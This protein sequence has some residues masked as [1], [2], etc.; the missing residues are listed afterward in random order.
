MA[1]DE[2]FRLRLPTALRKAMDVAAADE[3]ESRSA[4]VRNTLVAALKARGLDPEVM[5]LRGARQ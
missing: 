2:V 4:F 3:D 1:C 5:T